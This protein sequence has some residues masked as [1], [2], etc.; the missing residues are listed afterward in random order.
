[1]QPLS[2]VQLMSVQIIKGYKDMNKLVERKKSLLGSISVLDDLESLKVKQSARR[3][4]SERKDESFEFSQNDSDNELLAMLKV[5]LLALEKD[6]IAFAAM[7]P[8]FIKLSHTVLILMKR[9]ELFNLALSDSAVFACCIIGYFNPGYSLA[10]MVHVRERMN[11]S[12]ST[13]LS[14]SEVFQIF[15]SLPPSQETLS[16]MFLSYKSRVESNPSRPNLNPEFTFRLY[17][18]YIL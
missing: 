12:K 7:K 15:G 13:T 14:A 1:M 5:A 2:H 16:K 11:L 3:N 18:E 10:A 8:D 17:P 4:M 9:N 6:P